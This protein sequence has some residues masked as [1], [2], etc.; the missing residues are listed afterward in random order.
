MVAMR[1]VLCSVTVGRHAD[2]VVS[3][4]LP[5]TDRS[6]K[7]QHFDQFVAV[8]WKMRRYWGAMHDRAD[9]GSAI[10]RVEGPA[11]ANRVGDGQ[12]S[13]RSRALGAAAFGPLTLQRLAGNRAT[14]AFL[15][16]LAVQRKCGAS[17]Q[18]DSCRGASPEAVQRVGSVVIQRTPATG[19]FDTNVTPDDRTVSVKGINAAD[20][21]ANAMSAIG[22]EGGKVE[23]QQVGDI[24]TGITNG[25]IDG[26]I[27]TWK[28]I[29]TVPSVDESGFSNDDEKAAVKLLAARVAQHEDTHKSNE[30]SGRQGF[31]KTLKGKKDTD[32]D[33]AVAALECAV[34]KV[35]RNLDN[36]EGVITLSSANKVVV[37]GKDHPEY[38]ST[39][40]GGSPS[41]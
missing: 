29:K 7:G 4:G 8:A 28:V 18:C 13:H 19:Q 15:Q 24:D 11:V 16:G 1:D 9:G 12:T 5:R 30:I 22:G 40:S 14:T 35:Q 3:T 39:C 21:N 26:A 36:T 25:V 38:E 23:V 27:V 41:P 33:A 20:W 31:A 17:C 6:S 32:V 10:N 2:F 37:S 34:G